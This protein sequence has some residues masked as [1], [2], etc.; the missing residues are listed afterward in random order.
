MLY[1][2]QQP[3]TQHCS[4]SAFAYTATQLPTGSTSIHCTGTTVVQVPQQQWYKCPGGPT[5]AQNLQR[6]YHLLLALQ[7]VTQVL[8]TSLH[9]VSSIAV[10]QSRG[11]VTADN[12]RARSALQRLG[13]V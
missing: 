6:A 8:G 9:G 12:Q 5:Q 10:E 13:T 7:P 2:Q 4:H 1:N 3:R 11:A